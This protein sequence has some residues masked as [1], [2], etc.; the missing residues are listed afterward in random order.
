MLPKDTYQFI[1]GE[2]DE[3]GLPTQSGNILSL[4]EC[5]LLLQNARE[6]NDKLFRK[7]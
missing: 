4:E 3:S 7:I 1:I 6:M 2:D 5:E